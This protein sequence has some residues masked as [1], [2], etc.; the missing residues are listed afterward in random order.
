MSHRRKR[1]RRGQPT[2]IEVRVLG[3]VG[4]RATRCRLVSAICPLCHIYLVETS[5]TAI[6][7]V[8]TGVNSEVRVLH[9]DFVSNSHGAA[10][11]SSAST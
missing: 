8:G 5:T 10:D 6:P 4:R 7:T 2:T 3:M 9:V 11:S 1:A